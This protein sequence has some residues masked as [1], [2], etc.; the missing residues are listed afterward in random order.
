MEVFPKY[1]ARLVAGNAASIFPGLPRQPSGQGGG[2]YK[3]L[4]DEMRKIS[5]NKEQAGKI[6]ESIDTSTEDI[7][8]DFDRSTFMD[9]F[10]LDALEKTILALAFKRSSQSDLKTKGR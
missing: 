5:I 4:T 10:K 9:H 6:A 8:R 2:T 7:F 3:M 1:F